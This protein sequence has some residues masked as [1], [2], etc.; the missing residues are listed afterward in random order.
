MVTYTL[1]YIVGIAAFLVIFV[2]AL[3]FVLIITPLALLVLWLGDED[4]D[5]HI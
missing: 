4:Y 2:V 5:R 1:L 3:P